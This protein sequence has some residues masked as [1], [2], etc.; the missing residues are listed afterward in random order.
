M[1]TAEVEEAQVQNRWDVGSLLCRVNVTQLGE[2]R[3]ALDAASQQRVDAIISDLNTGK[4]L[5]QAVREH[6][7][8]A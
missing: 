5:D 1:L 2:G 6:I 8:G 3:C 7:A 4:P